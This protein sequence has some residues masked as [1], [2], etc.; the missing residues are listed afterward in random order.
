MV[1]AVTQGAQP[2]FLLFILDQ[3]GLIRNIQAKVDS[4]H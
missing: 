2:V 3:E 4:L 1:V